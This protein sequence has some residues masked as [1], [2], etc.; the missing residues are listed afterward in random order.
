MK[1][2]REVGAFNE[3]FLKCKYFI[4]EYTIFHVL[5][6]LMADL[7]HESNSSSTDYDHTDDTKQG[8][9]P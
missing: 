8:F 9:P 7:E 6:K 3:S 5:V 2:Y 1:K 4:S